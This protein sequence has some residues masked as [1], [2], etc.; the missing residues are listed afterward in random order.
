MGFAD[1]L[2]LLGI[3]YNSDEGIAT[4]REIMKFIQDCGHK[5]SKELAK[6]RGAF[7]IF[8]ESTLKNGAKQRNATVTTIA[9]TGTLSIIAGVSSGV[10]PIFGYVFIRNVM[11]GT[12]LI[13]V[14]PILKEALEERGLNR[15]EIMR[16]I[17]EQGT[18]QH[19]A[20]IPEEMKRVF[21]SAHDI[22]PIYH[23][24]MQ[25][26]FQENVDNAVSKT[27]NF[28]HDATVEDVDEVYRLAYELGLKG[29]TIYRDGSRESQVLNIGKVNNKESSVPTSCSE[30][31]QR[32]TNHLP[33]PRPEVV[34]G[35]TEKVRIGCGN[36]YITV[37]YDDKG[38]VEVFTNTGKAGGCPS[39][40]EATARLLSIGLR[41]GVDVKTLLSQ[42]KGIRC[43]STIRQHGLKVTSCPDAIAK[44]VQKVVD[45][46]YSDNAEIL[47]EKIVRPLSE[48]SEERE[49]CNANQIRF[50]PE[51]GAK[52]EH[53]GGCVVCRNCGYSKCG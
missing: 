49:P 15:P 34:K 46:N 44:V 17:A 51:C 21:V 43:P 32:E 18:L 25:A 19:I 53:E 6:R 3:P 39:Q 40:S 42:L 7:P 36:L 23:V 8:A 52:V 20:E 37:N 27:V 11:D 9:P 48:T 31:P 14:N 16:Q 47:E 30:C 38:I 45:L 5:A 26:A 33:R 28:G 22:S 35:F 1:L 29:V 24:K 12:E 10:E 2:L 50:C 41:S 4:G 13:E